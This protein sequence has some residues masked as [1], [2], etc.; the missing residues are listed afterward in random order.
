MEQP[1]NSETTTGQG[2]KWNR[3]IP[4]KESLRSWPEGVRQYDLMLKVEVTS[5]SS[6][7]LDDSTWLE[8]DWQPPTGRSSV[9][10]S[11]KE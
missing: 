6:G 2:T 4:D 9:P 3:L 10:S 1:E 5:E 11:T 7:Y 8:L